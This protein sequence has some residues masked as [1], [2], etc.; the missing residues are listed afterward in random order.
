M[1]LRLHE[2]RLGTLEPAHQGRRRAAGSLAAGLQV[3]H[4]VDRCPVDAHLEVDMWAETVAGAVGR[5]DHLT[6]ADGLTDAHTDRRLVCVAGRYAAAVLDARVVPI[7]PDL[8]GDRDPAGRCCA[9]RRAARHRDVDAGMKPAPP[10][11]ER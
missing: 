5:P 1:D 3:A 9:D 7:T 4:R 8:S 6:L 11:A 10:H 2:S